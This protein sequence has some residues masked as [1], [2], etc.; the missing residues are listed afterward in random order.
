L[1]STVDVYPVPIEVDEETPIESRLASA[2]GRHRR[3]LERFVEDHFDSLIVRLPGL[4]GTGI[5]KNIIYDFMHHNNVDQIHPDSR[6]QFYWLDQ[7]WR[8]I[9]IVLKH[10]ITLVNFATEPIS[11]EEVAREGFGILLSNRPQSPPAQYDFRTKH[12]ALLGGDRGYLYTKEQ[13]LTSL[14]HFL[15]DQNSQNQ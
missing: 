1:V 10:P 4:F 14:K 6:F 11:A 2:Y 15:A 13:V 7:L 3:V 8:D 5:K 9:Q 12:A